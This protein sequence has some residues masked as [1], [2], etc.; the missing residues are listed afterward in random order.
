[1]IRPEK[2]TLEIELGNSAFAGDWTGEVSCI[3]DRAVPWLH[4]WS[5]CTS[6]NS[7]TQENNTRHPL[8]DTNG[9][10]VG[11]LCLIGVWNDEE[12]EEEDTDE[13]EEEES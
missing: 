1:M 4:L 5:H 9:S 13:Q 2:L 8:F 12:D 7:V 10:R 11:T 3:L 6:F